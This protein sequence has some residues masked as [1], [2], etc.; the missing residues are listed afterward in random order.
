MNLL[1]PDLVVVLVKYQNR[2]RWFR[3]ERDLW[4]LDYRKWAK[5]FSAV[6]YDVESGAD[7]RFGIEV[8]D[9]V[10]VDDFLS[11]IAN[12]E[13]DREKLVKALANRL[14]AA[15]SW[16]DV[17]KLFPIVLI[18]FDG[19]HVAAFYHDGIPMERY[20]PDGW[21]SEFEDFANKYNE[22]QLPTSEKFWVQDGT[23]WLAVL[24]ERGEK[25]EQ[26]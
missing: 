13:V 10:T 21:T 14:P 16:W 1:E 7:E 3:G 24:N 20:V 18:D 9:T 6:G 26:R 2:F 4:V 25:L 12:L 19:K 23:D 17:G 15:K 5:D 8:V 11:K 22:S